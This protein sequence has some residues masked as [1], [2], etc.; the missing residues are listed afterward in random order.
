[1]QAKQSPQ[2]LKYTIAEWEKLPEYPRY[3]LIDGQIVMMAPA[4]WGHQRISFELGR[5]LGN[6]L[7][8]KRCVAAQD[9]GVQLDE[10]GWPTAFRPDIVVVCDPAKI[11]PQGVIGAP[12]LIIEILSPSTAGRDKVLK[13]NR[14]RQAGVREYWIVDPIHQIVDVLQ[15]ESGPATQTYTRDDKINVGILDG[16]QVDLS[17]VFPEP[18]VEE[19]PDIDA[20]HKELSARR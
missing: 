15:W 19:T 5:Q 16:C 4:A 18:A 13:L 20:S 7:Q 14:Y 2:N 6:Y 1:M 12:D 3:E 8:G 17:L 9:V 11:R 10:R